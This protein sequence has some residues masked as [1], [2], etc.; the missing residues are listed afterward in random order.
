M[1]RHR[2]HPNR[3]HAQRRLTVPKDQVDGELFNSTGV[4]EIHPLHCVPTVDDILVLPEA[5]KK[6]G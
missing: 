3:D 5:P 6:N 2:P 1:I 4:K